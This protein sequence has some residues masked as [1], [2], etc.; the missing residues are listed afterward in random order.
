M[1]FRFVVILH[2][3]VLSALLVPAVMAAVN[4]TPRLVVVVTLDQFPHEYL[5]RFQEYFGPSGFR[6]LMNGAVFANATY[7]HANTSTGPGHAVILSG[8]YGRTNGI[9]TN[10]WY[11]RTQHRRVYCVEDK[12][13]QLLGSDAEGRSPANFNGLTYGD[14][15][16]INTSFRSK[17]ISISNK[18]RAAILTGGK[19]AN[20]VL[21]MRD[22]L[23]VTST[24]YAQ[25]LPPWVQKFNGS[26]KI[27]SY[28][29][30]VW[31][32]ILPA[33][34]YDKV[35]RDDA[36]Y[37]EGGNGMGRTFP[38][39]I[40][41]KDAQSRTSS[42]YS[43]LLSSPFG[44]EV[45]AELAKQAVSGELLGKRGV[46]DLLSVS[47]SS[48][49]YVGHSFGPYSQEMLDMV[50]RMDRILSDFLDFLGREIGRD[51]CLFVLTSDHGVSPIPQFLQT[52]SAAPVIKRFSSATLV[53]AVES[54]LTSRFPRTQKGLWIEH[55]SGG[56]L[57]FSQPALAAANA[58][59]E[60]AGRVVCDLLV[61]QPE[62]ACAFTREQIRT[63]TPTTVL[64]QRL[65][66]SFFERRSGD[67]I[68]AVRPL[69]TEGAEEPGATH[70]SPV[71]SD[72]HVALLFR[73]A[74]V[75]PGVYQSEASP[76]DIAPTLSAL[77]GV[78]FTP[79]RDGRV[80]EEAVDTRTPGDK[81]TARPR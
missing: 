11:D 65:R 58:T 54:V 18:D 31:E 3:F 63:L 36:P 33:A 67:V 44:A 79:D 8:T 75:R 55:S 1:R 30:S 37:E 74:G 9:V 48:T 5:T 27:N 12:S 73:G 66:N 16:R 81:G 25:T 42:Y 40:R 61:S 69:W 38:H 23:F 26:G 19:F 59:A 70:G 78:E 56:S 32:K 39:P 62:V 28:F 45:L 41:G 24:Y 64:E 10:S 77:T 43:A 49:D 35:D 2:L 34:A 60:Q 57:F 68:Y 50:V 15:L 13:V 29:G 20:L 53:A 22:S 7:K 21:W 52:H 51:R 80:L 46:T 72:A 14:M 71:E 6:Y 76:A 4:T 47:F 17:V